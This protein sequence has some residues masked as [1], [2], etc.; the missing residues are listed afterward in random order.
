MKK[1]IIQFK[2]A[3]QPQKILLILFSF[4]YSGLHAQDSIIPSGSIVKK[5]STGQFKFLEGP[6]WYNDSAL[7]FVDDGL[8]GMGPDFYKYDPVAKQFSKW[9][10]T[11][12]HCT[13][14]S[15]DKDGNLIGASANIIMIN[16]AG[17]ISKTLASGYNNKTFNN[18]NDLIADSRGGVYFTDPDFFLTKPPQGK[19]AVYYIDSTG[20]VKRVIDDVGE[21]NGIILSPDGTKLYVDNGNTKYLYS[22]DVSSDG[23]VSGK[24]N[25]AELQTTGDT[26]A[27]SDGMAIDIYGNIYI[28]TETGI[29][30]ISPQGVAITTITVPSE[31]TN[32]DF[33]G[34]DFKSLYI[35][36]LHNLYSIDLNYPGYAVSRRAGVTGINSVPVKPMA[37]IYPNPVRDILYIR[38]IPSSVKSVKI[39]NMD[40]QME[41]ITYVIKKDSGI[42]I[43]TQKLTPGMY[44]LGI[45]INGN[46]L[47]RKFLKE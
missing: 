43:N 10:S 41:S 6:V 47:T 8:A 39:I 44:L 5:L 31:P 3:L 20:N 28:A 40:G 9:P 30:V 36:T 15:C 45:E 23:S 32:C 11:A 2:S 35:T 16:K 46:M 27:G 42:E 18:P 7:L 21:P 13:G 34:S 29:Q 26:S 24:Q 1:L 17:Q 4:G 33:G 38:Q 14:L 25:L 19:T 22:W 12:P 37:E